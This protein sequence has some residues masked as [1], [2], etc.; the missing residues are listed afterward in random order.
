M[1]NEQEL[2]FVNH[3]FTCIKDGLTGRGVVEIVG[4]GP[5]DRFHAG[6]L[7]PLAPQL[8]ITEMVETENVF[9]SLSG[10]N[11]MTNGRQNTLFKVNSESTMSIDFQVHVSEDTERFVLKIKPSFS[12][13]Y[14]VFPT[15]TDVQVSLDMSQQEELEED[16]A[17]NDIGDSTAD[18]ADQEVEPDVD[19]LKGIS[20]QEIAYHAT[21]PITQPTEKVEEV[22]L[23]TIILPR[24]FRKRPVEFPAIEI[25]IS[26]QNLTPPL[27]L[28]NPI[29]SV[30]A[31]TRAIILAEDTDLW[32]HLGKPAD[33]H[34]ELSGVN[35]LSNDETYRTALQS[36]AKGE[37]ALPVWRAYLSISGQPTLLAPSIGNGQV[38][39]INVALVN[40]TPSV[41]KD[42]QRRA[43]LEEGA[44]FDCGFSV[45]VEGCKLIPFEFQG[46]PKDY[47]YDR[48]FSAIGSNCVALLDE[49]DDKQCL[50]TETVPLYEQPW[51]RTR[52]DLPVAFA[53]LDDSA[54]SNPLGKLDEVG[55]RMDA[56]LAEWDI[57]LDTKA[58]MQL[59]AEQIK[60]CFKDKL[61]FATEVK[62]FKLGVE[63]LRKDSN[64]LR[65]FRLMNRVF[66]ENG[67]ERN[68]PITS[69]RLF[70]LAFMVIQLP[71]LAAREHDLRGTD[72][73][74]KGLKTAL[75]RVDVLWFPTGGGKT[76]AYL[77]L[78]TTA[79][80]YDRLR[81]KS[82]GVSAWLRFPLRML[83][84]QQL[85]RLSRVLARA[86]II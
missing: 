78:I 58:S 3:L 33:S 79:L 27:E 19:L 50:Y 25:M 63:S 28:R 20:D 14:S 36:A 80:F 37:V 13:Y 16:I 43:Q 54:S 6:V 73:Y 23:E 65:A 59:D 2:H 45:E 44:L 74:T 85:E 75:E 49:K 64:L 67:Q 1:N 76:E 61:N 34:R 8:P 32:Q 69:W 66:R 83:S 71:T 31:N 46:T 7:L 60:V 10:N 72:E 38:L 17:S 47:R 51:Y 22:Q 26:P 30:I 9:D 24:K 29:D 42:E 70:Q 15:R 86:E 84:L 35:L 53:D 41:P 52:N 40:A 18:P 5:R 81:G 82:R 4:E 11:G 68:P 12:V 57:Y 39:R 77:G 21:E 62:G 56:Y 48:S 55:H